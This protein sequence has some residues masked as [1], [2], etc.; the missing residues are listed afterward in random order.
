MRKVYLSFL[1]RGAFDKE[2]KE[3]RYTPA[4][5]ELQGRKSKETEFVQAAEIE[6]LGAANFDLFIVAATEVSRD[7]HFASLEGQLKD[8][9]AKE[10]SLITIGEDMSAEGQ[11]NWFEQI[12][13]R[14]EF[15]DELTV[16][17]TH[18][19][20]LTPII[21][22]AAINFLQKARNITIR[23][24]YYGAFEKRDEFGCAPIVDMKDFYIVN[25]WAEAV[26]RLVEDADARK[27]A[28]VAS[29]APGFQTG[30]LND[31]KI[32][33]ALEDLTNAIR[34]VEVNRVAEKAKTAL[35]LI[36][37]QRTSASFTG[38]TLLDLVIDKFSLLVIDHP[39]SGKYDRD[40]FVIQKV[41]IQLLLEHKLFMQAYTVMREFIGSIGLIEVDKAGYETKQGRDQRYRFSEVFIK[42]VELPEQEWH[43]P[44]KANSGVSRLEPYYQKLKALGVVELLRGFVGELIRYRNGFDHAWTSKDRA[45]SDIEVAGFRMFERLRQILSLMEESG[46]LR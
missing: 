27:M 13:S 7:S 30:G 40:Y 12:L 1:G 42:M 11:W 37:K 20:R 29:N 15:R 39:P 45:P 16:D 4:M 32:V 28:A 10:I 41:I 43:F 9:G 31:K 34:N 5:Y 14:I 44:E 2:V 35:E 25:E 22:S 33:E 26:S 18:G 24:V 21:F 46:L 23:A 3:Y 8:L 38:K 17:M 19:F 36:T 6:I